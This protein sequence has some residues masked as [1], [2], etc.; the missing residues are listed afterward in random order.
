MAV[1]M[2]SVSE[3]KGTRAKRSLKVPAATLCEGKGTGEIE[4]TAGDGG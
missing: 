3:T 2:M 4:E 1:M